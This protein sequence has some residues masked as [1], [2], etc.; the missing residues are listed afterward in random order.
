M[1]AYQ[2]IVRDN[3]VSEQCY[4]CMALCIYYLI[5]LFSLAV[6]YSSIRHLL[7]LTE[8]E[9]DLDSDKEIPDIFSQVSYIATCSSAQSQGLFDH[10]GLYIAT[11]IMDNPLPFFC[12]QVD[13]L[14]CY[15]DISGY[16]DGVLGSEVKPYLDEFGGTAQQEQLMVGKMTLE[17]VEVR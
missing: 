13:Q 5:C 12:I 2:N 7:E 10:A 3:F 15:S 1:K 8:G 14:Q 11:D 6:N 17:Q 4:T 9:T 16:K